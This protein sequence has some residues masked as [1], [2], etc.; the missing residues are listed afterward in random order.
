MQVRQLAA[1][2]M[3]S[4]RIIFGRQA[5]LIHQRTLGIDPR[6]VYPAPAKPMVSEAIT[7]SQD[8]NDDRKLLGTLYAL[9][10]RC[11][12]RLRGRALFPRRAG[13]LIRYSD[14]MESKRQLQL[15][16]HSYWEHDLYCPV[17]A[18]FLKA[19]NRRV[20][21]RFMKVWFWDFST[22]AQL[23]LFHDVP[24]EAT[25]KSLVIKTLDRIRE[26]YG[27][28]AIKCGRTV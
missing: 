4:M 5:L 10:E 15:P 3:N 20:R 14:Q 17:E 7:F 12:Y 28:D 18:L 1:L 22:S 26:R 24:S 25:K 13:L 6:P 9:V 19:C 23:S 8:E 11:A 16:H 2:D 21:V 27:E